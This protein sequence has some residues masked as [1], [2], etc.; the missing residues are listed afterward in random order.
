[1]NKDD[2]FNEYNED[3]DWD[4]WMDEAFRDYKNRQD[5]FATPKGSSNHLPA[6]IPATKKT[7]KVGKNNRYQL[8][9]DWD[10]NPKTKSEKMKE[11]LGRLRE[12]KMLRRAEQAKKISWKE[13]RR[14]MEYEVLVGGTSLG[15]VRQNY[16]GKWK[17]YPSFRWRKNSYNRQVVVEADYLNFN[18]A[19]RA[20]VDLWTVS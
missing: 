20:L 7:R 16:N 12:E 8:P 1:M 17:I 14:N 19:G 10:Y 2:W 11:E 9:I 15:R 18:E 3:L 4:A 13:I 6:K 5:P